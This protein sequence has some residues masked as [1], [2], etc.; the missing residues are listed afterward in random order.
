VDSWLEDIERARQYLLQTVGLKNVVLFGVRASAFLALES[1][2]VEEGIILWNPCSSGRSFIRELKVLA[3]VGTSDGHQAV[4]ESG[5][6]VFDE[7][8]QQSIERLKASDFQSQIGR[9]LLVQRSDRQSDAVLTESLRQRATS[10]HCM[11]NDDFISAFRE[12]HNTQP[13]LGFIESAVEW[14]RT[15][16]PEITSS[17]LFVDLSTD[18]TIRQSTVLPNVTRFVE[19]RV[20]NIDGLF[21][22]LTHTPGTR[23]IVLIGNGGSAHHAGA[24]RL[25]VDLARGLAAQGI[26]CL[27]YDLANLGE[28]VDVQTALECGATTP[29]PEENN[30]YPKTA[31]R[32]V[33]AIMSWARQQG[34]SRVI[35][36]GLC[37]GAYAAFDVARQANSAIPL[38]L[39][40]INPLTFDWQEGMSLDIPNEYSN[41]Q[42][43][44]AYESAAKDWGRWKRLLTGN[45]DYQL[46]V[47]HLFDS[48]IISFTSRW[49]DV[50]LRLGLREAPRLA[51]DLLQIAASGCKLR[52]YFAERDPGLEIL[53]T[54]GERCLADLR[55][56]GILR[57]RTIKGADHTFKR[58]CERDELIRT[59]IEDMEHEHGFSA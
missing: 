16:Y 37:A 57:I 45:I 26:D 22:I 48:T 12:P 10:L 40:L 31:G 4:L 18:Q 38:E 8:L 20:Q 11:T 29:T 50:A 43:A 46:L 24:N 51:Q 3:K 42:Q 53:S 27:R 59:I 25:H 52:F 6:L 2:K 36:A 15:E 41:L 1:C 39:V 54:A 28:S 13:P 19:E 34:Y 32:D 21:A 7:I 33:N 58:I 30:P 17:G 55:K 23:S 49:R 14:L 44:K 9:V 47:R 35:L 5:G 56:Q